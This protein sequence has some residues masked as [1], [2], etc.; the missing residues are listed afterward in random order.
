MIWIEVADS[1]YVFY[2]EGDWQ[3]L[4][5]TWSEDLPESDPEIV[6]PD[7]M[8]QPIRGFGKVWR[9]NP[10][11]RERLG[12]AL[13]VELA[14]ESELQDQLI[15]TDDVPITFMRTFN[16]QVFALALHDSDQGDWAIAAS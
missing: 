11:V 4:E 2:K 14:F 1:I 8:F 6:V 3:R 7:G 12:W 10:E 15:V 16:G 5:D 13:G 9:E